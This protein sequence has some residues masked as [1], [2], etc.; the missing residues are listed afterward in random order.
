MGL[1]VWQLVAAVALDHYRVA[2]AAHGDD[3]TAIESL[4]PGDPLGIAPADGWD[5]AAERGSLVVVSPDG[6]LRAGDGLLQRRLEMLLPGVIV[7]TV[8]SGS[9]LGRVLGLDTPVPQGLARFIERM[10]PPVGADA[11]DGAVR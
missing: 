1:T 7:E 11:G 4:L 2:L 6:P 3:D 10:A 9:E 5:L 8:R